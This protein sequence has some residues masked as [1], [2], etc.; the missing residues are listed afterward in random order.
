MERDYI[1]I[2]CTPH[3]EQCAQVGQ[4]NYPE[5]SRKE[6]RAFANQ[7]VRLFGEPPEGASLVIKSFPHEFGSYREVVCWFEV[8]NE[9]AR[10]YAFKLESEAPANWD[11]E[12]KKELQEAVHV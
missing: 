9:E 10:T 2:G 4:D 12:A 8:D 6:C 5:Q 1:D 11:E 7:L 3:D